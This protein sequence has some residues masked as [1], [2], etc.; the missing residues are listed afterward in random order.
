MTDK[1][2]ATYIKLF[3]VEEGKKLIKEADQKMLL[4]KKGICRNGKDLIDYK[5]K[6]GDYEIHDLREQNDKRRITQGK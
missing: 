6:W 4:I 1:M 3:G 5:N 2:K